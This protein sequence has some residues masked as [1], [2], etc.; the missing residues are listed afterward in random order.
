M[1]MQVGQWVGD[2]FQVVGSLKG[3]SVQASMIAVITLLVSSMK[4]TVFRQLVWDKLGGAKVLAAPVLSLLMVVIGA[5][6][7]GQ[8]FSFGVLL[9]ALTTGAGALALHEVLDAV[10]E[11][12]FVKPWMKPAIEWISKTLGA[13]AAETP[14]VKG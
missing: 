14:A 2:L 4:V 1:E 9:V 13:K 3:M 11:M 12:K 10:K 8:K 6:A 7:T 5:L